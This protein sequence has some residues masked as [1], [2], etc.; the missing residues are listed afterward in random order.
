MKLVI[1]HDRRLLVELFVCSNLAFL[2]LDVAIAHA[3]N[4]FGQPA[5][6][7]PVGFAAI[8]AAALVP[9]IVRSW[10]RGASPGRAGTV[11]GWTGVVVGVAGLVF[12]LRSQFFVATTLHNLVY[13]APFV[14]PLSFAGLGLLLLANRMVPMES[15]EWA[16]WVLFLALAGFAGNF[17]LSLTDHAQ[18]GFFNRLEWI[19]LF[20]SALAVGFLLTALLRPLFPGF[21][22]VCWGV[23]ALQVATGLVGFGL[24]VWADLHGP[25]HH[26][27]LDFLYGAPA[28]APMLFADLAVL[29]GIG[30]MSLPVTHPAS[31]DASPPAAP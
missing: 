3:V 22:R 6:W 16:E 31:D 23:L 1:L 29:A 11:V 21:L 4:A 13:S 19:P 7:I 20:S 30:L 2:V 15:L 17:V 25:T 10:R 9:G 14:A 24:H 12:H 5:E 18:N 27:A 8:G 28:F 26:P